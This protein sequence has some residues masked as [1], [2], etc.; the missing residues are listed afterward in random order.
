VVECDASGEP[1][2]PVIEDCSPDTCSAGA[3]VDPC[4]PEALA[5]SYSGCVFYAVDLPQWGQPL[6]GFAS[7]AADQQFA[8]AVANQWDVP[9]IVVVEQDDAGPGEPPDVVEVA[10]V[11]VAP[12]DLAEIPLPQR[13]VSG[14]GGPGTATPNRSMLTALAYRVSTSHPATVYQFNPQNNPG[15]FSNDA[16]LLMPVN[17]L[18]ESYVVLGWPGMGGVVVPVFGLCDNRSYLTVV[19]TRAGTRVRVVPSTPVMAGDGVAETAAGDEI[20]VT[21]GEFETLNLEGAD[22]GVYGETDF[23]GTRIEADGPVAVWSGVECITIGTGCCCD[24]LEEQ[25]FPRSSL[26]AEYVA[27]RTQPRG[28]EPDYFRVLAL[29]DGTSVTTSLPRPDDSFVLSTGEMRQF[30]AHADFTLTAS[31]AVVL[32]QFLAGQDDSG[33]IGDPSFILVPPLAQHRSRYIFLVPSGYANNYLLLSVPAGIDVSLDGAAAARCSRADAGSVGGAAYEAVRCPVS[34]GTH[35][36]E[37]PE[38]FGLV[39]EGWGAGPVSYGY[40]GGMDLEP[41]NTECTSDADCGPGSCCYG[42]ACST[43][44]I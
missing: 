4:S 24:H 22:Y 31:A 9:M 38:P 43:C 21:L 41:V 5:R 18:D 28:A 40:T 33:G 27:V 26:G 7:I 19:G 10:V 37:A 14:Y 25:L 35:T 15:A 13:E 42:G 8:V 6:M 17:A 34:P 29:D 44:I 30:T 1:T 3:C 36:V 12:N 23:T 11:T 39:V 16:S 2:G 32:G 20:V